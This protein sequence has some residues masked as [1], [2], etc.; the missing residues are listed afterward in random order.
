MKTTQQRPFAVLCSDSQNVCSILTP[1]YGNW[2]LTE[3]DSWSVA[4]AGK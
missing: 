3:Q 4:A 1:C 2:L